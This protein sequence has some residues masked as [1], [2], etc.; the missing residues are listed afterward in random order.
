MN[1]VMKRRNLSVIG[2]LLMLTSI[3]FSQS[4]IKFP[5][6]IHDFGYV[7]EGTQAS[8]LF[9]FEN[10]G[11]DSLKLTEVR[12]SCGCTTPNWPRQAIL[13]GDESEI[14]VS[15][16]SQGRVGAFYK[17]IHVSSNAKEGSKDLI[18]KGVVISPSML[19]S[20]TLKSTNKTAKPSLVF[21]KKL[22]NYGKTEKGKSV[23]QDVVITNISKVKVI[24]K[25]TSTGCGCTGTDSDIEIAPGQKKTI[26]VRYSPREIGMHSDVLVLLTDDI[27]Q[28]VY[29]LK[30]SAEVQESLATPK[31]LL[32]NSQ[33][34]GF[35][36]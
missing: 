20:D 3:S 34:G 14:A 24:I 1:S 4:S 30:L 8:Y 7:L 6:E 36:F 23:Y 25:S 19:P 9:K 10:N 22:V 35:G 5:I 21:D 32:E 12:P 17:T 16:N 13:S 15:Y 26:S 33:G 31:N 11:D 2:C 29:E 18:I 28:P 27:Q